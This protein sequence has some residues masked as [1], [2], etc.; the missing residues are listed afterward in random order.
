MAMT[1]TTVEEFLQPLTTESDIRALV[2]Q[3]YA[4]GAI[5]VDYVR[6]DG[7]WVITSTWALPGDSDVPLR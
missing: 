1:K 3:R 4:A 5:K 7:K 6:E 2:Q